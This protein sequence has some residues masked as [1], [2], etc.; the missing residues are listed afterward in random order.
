MAP[1]YK[2]P[3][4][5]STREVPYQALVAQYDPDF[6][7]LKHRDIEY[8]FD[9]R[10]FRADPYNRGAYNR[11]SNVYPVGQPYGGLDASVEAALVPT[12][13][14]ATPGLYQ[15]VATGPWA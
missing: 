3:T 6:E 10:A 2:P 9:G 4:R 11:R 13:G 8:T 14:N 12:E 15:G 5:V 7:R 1:R